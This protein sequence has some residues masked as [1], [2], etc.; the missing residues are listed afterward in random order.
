MRKGSGGG[1][2]ENMG[3][4]GG[5]EGGIGN[6]TWVGGGGG[7]RWRG[8]AKGNLLRSVFLFLSSSTTSLDS[9][10]FSYSTTSL[11]SV[12]FSFSS[13]TSS[14][15]VFFSFFFLLLLSLFSFIFPDRRVE[16]VNYQLNGF[17]SQT[18]FLCD[19]LSITVIRLL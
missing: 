3:W 4:G 11:S 16:N 1:R 14:G 2:E 19:P 8:M 18:S 13:T 12:C 9:V 10:C 5:G 15:S 7:G 6:R 17:C